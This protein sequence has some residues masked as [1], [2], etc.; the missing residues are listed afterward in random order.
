[1]SG[2]TLGR[3]GNL[4]FLDEPTQISSAAAASRRL[5]VRRRRGGDTAS[6]RTLQRTARDGRTW[7]DPCRRQRALSDGRASLRI[8][9][10]PGACPGWAARKSRGTRTE[11]GPDRFEMGRRAQPRDQADDREAARPMAGP[12]FARRLRRRI[13]EEAPPP[14]MPAA[15]ARP[16]PGDGPPAD[17]PAGEF[18]S[19]LRVCFETA[20]SRVS[21]CPRSARARPI[22]V[23]KP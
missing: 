17:R 4:E 5:R 19:Q 13:A 16:A 8:F 1:M 7:P 11:V 22:F 2:L 23:R 21:A 3:A 10:Q 12:A 20:P 6:A 14:G 9:G 18:Q 15:D